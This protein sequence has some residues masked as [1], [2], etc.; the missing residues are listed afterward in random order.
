[1]TEKNAKKIIR[2]EKLINYNLNEDRYNKENEV[3]I[4]KEGDYWIVY[5]TDERASTVTNSKI[6]FENE[7]EAWDNLIKRLRADKVLRE[8]E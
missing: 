2:E 3:V 8:L 5:S 7:E 6:I 4:K 1:M